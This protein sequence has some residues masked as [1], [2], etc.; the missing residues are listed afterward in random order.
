MG[1]PIC[2][3][4]AAWRSVESDLP[5]WTGRGWRK[6]ASY[7]HRSQRELLRY[8]PRNWVTCLRASIGDVR[9]GRGGLI[10]RTS[11]ESKDGLENSITLPPDN[12]ALVGHGGCVRKNR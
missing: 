11:A 9:N 6:A 7:V 12:M 5:R 8:H 3:P 1:G 4:G 10:L 2:L